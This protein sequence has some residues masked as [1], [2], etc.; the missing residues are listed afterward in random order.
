MSAPVKAPPERVR[1]LAAE[2]M[3]QATI[4]AELGVSRERIR[5]ICNRHGIATISGARDLDGRTEV[6]DLHAEGLTALEIAAE[7]GRSDVVVR[8]WLRE[9]GLEPH[10]ARTMADDIQV[11]IEAGMT[12]SECARHLDKRV[13]VIYNVAKRA[14]LKFRFKHSGFAGSGPKVPA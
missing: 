13:Q 12:M 11:C 10:R 2:E 8:L 7:T 4:A 3:S 1:A 9:A 14:G 6:I 5:Q